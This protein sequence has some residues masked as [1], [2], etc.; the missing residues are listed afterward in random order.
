MVKEAIAASGERFGAVSRVGRT[1]Y[2][3]LS[4]PASARQVRDAKVKAEG[5]DRARAPRELRPSSGLRRPCG[6]YAG[7]AT[8]WVVTASPG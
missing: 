8:R 7:K 3:A 1:Y 6:S 5:G 2:E 4:R